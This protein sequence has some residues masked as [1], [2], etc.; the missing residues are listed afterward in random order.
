MLDF[1][2][3]PQKGREPTEIKPG[4]TIPGVSPTRRHSGPRRLEDGTQP[5][6]GRREDGQRMGVGRIKSTTSSAGTKSG[7]TALSPRPTVRHVAENDAGQRQ[8]S[9][10]RQRR[11][12]SFKDAMQK[13][14][15]VLEN[16]G[17]TARKWATPWSRPRRRF[18]SSTASPATS[19]KT[20]RRSPGA[21]T[22]PPT[23]STAFSRTEQ[24]QPEDQRPQQLA[25]PTGLGSRAL[26]ARSR[27]CKTSTN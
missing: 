18:I 26:S 24:V 7:S 19:R 22:R 4:E 2:R 3:S 6:N 12:R 16:V 8:R 20:G 23:T 13:F 10:R 25:F 17:N 21:S 15:T 9:H 27:Q 5:H 11:V 1:V 14:P